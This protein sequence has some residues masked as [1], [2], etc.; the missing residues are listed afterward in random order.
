MDNNHFKIYDPATRQQLIIIIV[1][2]SENSLLSLGSR[3]R[4]FILD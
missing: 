3:S 4:I 1:R 2:A